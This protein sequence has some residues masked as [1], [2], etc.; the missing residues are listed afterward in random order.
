MKKVFIILGVLSMVVAAGYL[1]ATRPSAVSDAKLT[2]ASVESKVTSGAKLYDVRTAEEY[3]AG[4][5]PG[6]INWSLQDIEAGKLPDT[7]KDTVI[8]LYC[9]SG[10][11]S[12]QATE[13]LKKAGYSDITD[14]GGLSDVEALGAKLI[15]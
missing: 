13:L 12:A 4:H 2:F 11:R 1:Y 5:F 3:G 15:K 7:P 8:F 6:A 14:L 9:R 10:N